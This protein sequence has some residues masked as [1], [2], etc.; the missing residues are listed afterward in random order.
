MRSEP[1]QAESSQKRH[2]EAQ[3][4]VVSEGYSPQIPF[5]GDLTPQHNLEKFAKL[6]LSG[7]CVSVIP[8]MPAAQL[9]PADI[10]H[11]LKLFMGL[12]SKLLA[13]ILF[14]D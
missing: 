6:L 4:Q 9:T 14:T 5:Q 7:L 2:L 11:M 8:M 1:C 3:H 10:I 12:Q 13:A